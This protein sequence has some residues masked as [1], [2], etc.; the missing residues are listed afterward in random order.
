MKRGNTCGRSKN[1][2]DMIYNLQEQLF[3]TP[4]RFSSRTSPLLARACFAYFWVQ[5]PKESKRV[6]LSAA[7]S[8][9]W[10]LWHVAKENWGTSWSTLSL[11]LERLPLRLLMIYI[12]PTDWNAWRLA[13]RSI[14]SYIYLYPEFSTCQHA[15][16]GMTYGTLHTW[17]QHSWHESWAYVSLLSRSPFFLPHLKSSTWCFS[18]FC[19][20]L[21]FPA[22]CGALPW[23]SPYF[24][25]PLTLS[26]VLAPLSLELSFLICKMGVCKIE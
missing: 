16:P 12:N 15:R 14:A 8:L 5:T 25:V 10:G 1:T 22:E 3:I 26:L 24:P 18:L 17:T 4:W 21:K 9:L 11:L 13:G 20:V 23:F 2:V 6:G 19:L 7:E